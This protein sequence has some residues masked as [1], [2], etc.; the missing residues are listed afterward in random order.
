MV[1]QDKLLF[2]AV[3]VK[4]KRVTKAEIS[5]SSRFRG[6]GVSSHQQLG[7]Q[8]KSRDS[9]SELAGNCYVFLRLMREELS[10]FACGISKLFL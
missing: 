7:K 8:G 5:V 1:V 2:R 9:W 6:Y 4:H 3:I 10:T